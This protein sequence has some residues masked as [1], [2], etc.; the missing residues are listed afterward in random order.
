[1]R[2]HAPAELGQ[3]DL[4]AFAMEQWAAE[5]SLQLFRSRS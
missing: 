4:A 5:L 3:R 1:M 2:L